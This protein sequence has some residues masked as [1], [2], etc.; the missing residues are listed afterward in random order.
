MKAGIEPSLT[1]CFSGGPLSETGEHPCLRGRKGEDIM[2]LTFS[3]MV[4]ALTFAFYV[5]VISTPLQQ[6]GQR[7]ESLARY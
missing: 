5:I 4:G 2:K 7:L 6:I 1:T 3:A